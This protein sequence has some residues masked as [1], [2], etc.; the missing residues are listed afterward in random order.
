MRAWVLDRAR[1]ASFVFFL[2]PSFG[3][4]PTQKPTLPDLA[5][6]PR[7]F[8]RTS[9]WVSLSAHGVGSVRVQVCTY[10]CMD[11]DICALYYA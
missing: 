3:G 1:V 7:A 2:V 4:S 5:V 10:A 11:S 8:V 6:G 9:L